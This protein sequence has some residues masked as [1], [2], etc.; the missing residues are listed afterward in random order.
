VGIHSD[1]RDG[2]VGTDKALRT[3]HVATFHTI[4]ADYVARVDW[5]EDRL[6]AERTRALRAL[7]A[8]ALKGSSWHRKRLAGIDVARVTERDL[9]AVPVMTKRDLMDNFDEIVTDRRLSREICE[10]HLERLEGDAYLCEEY[11]AVASGG[12]SGQRGV[13]VYGWDAWA[14][15][16]ASMARFP[17]R[18]WMSDPRLAGV[19][20]V[21]AV[22][23]ASKPTHVSAAFRLTFSSTRD[24][25]HLFPV[26]QPLERIVADLNSLQPTELIGYS[27]LLGCLARQASAGQLRISP[28]RVAA[29]SEPLLPQTRAAIRAAWNVPI[30]ARYGM[31]EGVFAGFCGQRNHLPDD[32]CIFEPVAVDG[33]PTKTGSTSDKVYITNLY[34]DTLP[35]IRFEVTD[36]V[37][38]LR[39][40]CPCGSVFRT[41][42][43]PQGR[44]DDTFIYPGG[45]SIHPHVFRSALIQ[46]PRIVEYQVRQTNVGAEI[47]VVVDGAVDTERLTSE[48][49]D[50][51]GALGLDRPDVTIT[52]VSAIQ[53]QPTGKLK[54]F[55]PLP[56]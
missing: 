17:H 2:S 20:R 9:E 45:I 54:L 3:R 16:W 19:P 35:L 18:D 52:R 50:A 24:P 5:P 28:R 23:A 27:S 22:I 21:A 29:I 1:T 40:P 56:N 6:R 55:V 36:E 26:N 49:V 48:L 7:I 44:L 15:C 51:L 14:I 39:G 43:D 12:S 25:E 30:G 4:F 13:Y 11:H 31:S 10:R 32:L 41:I 34:N 8:A 38:V 46:Q 33:T 37:T 42:A 47:S 53:R